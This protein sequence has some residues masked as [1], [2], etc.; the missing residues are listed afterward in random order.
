MSRLINGGIILSAPGSGLEPGSVRPPPAEVCS[1]IWPW[2]GELHLLGT[3]PPLL[4]L[5]PEASH[6][7]PR[8]EAWLSAPPWP[9]LE[10]WL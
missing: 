8:P 5:R 10:A 1:E 4:W 2:P 3:A 7:R 6:P 9:R